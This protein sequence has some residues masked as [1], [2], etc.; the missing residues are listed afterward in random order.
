MRLLPILILLLGGVA[1]LAAQGR[2]ALQTGTVDLPPGFEVRCSGGTDSFPGTILRA[3]SS[4]VIH[5]D[6]GGMAGTRVTPLRRD[7]FLWMIEHRAD[8]LRAFT[9]LYVEDG[10]RRIATTIHADDGGHSFYLPA[11]FVADVREER[12][13]AEFLLIT[14]SYRHGPEP[15][16]RCTRRR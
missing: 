7:A 1:P 11:N 13:V 14:S 12:D 16:T 2:A 10:H 6:I 15:A 8:T 3:D 5:Y 4:L 9:G